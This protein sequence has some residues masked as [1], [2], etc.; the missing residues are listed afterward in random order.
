[1]SLAI[2]G[3]RERGNHAG[4]A[5]GDDKTATP[6]NPSPGPG[7]RG[8][9]R[10]AGAELECDPLAAPGCFLEE[11]TAGKEGDEGFLFLRAQDAGEDED[12][13]GAE[14][15]DDLHRVGA[16]DLAEDVGDDH[17]EPAPR[18]P[19]GEVASGQGD[20]AAV[21]AAQVGPGGGDGPGVA[22]EGLHAGGAEFFG[23]HGEDGGTGADVQGGPTGS[24]PPG[25]GAQEAK[26]GGGGGVLAGPESHGPGDAEQDTGRRLRGGPPA[27][28]VQDPQVPV[29]APRTAGGIG[30]GRE[31]QPVDPVELT[32]PLV[33]QLPQRGGLRVVGLEAGEGPSGAGVDDEIGF[34]QGEPCAPGFLVHG[35][36][37]APP[38][39]DVAAGAAGANHAATVDLFSSWLKPAGGNISGMI[40]S[41]AQWMAGPAG[42]GLKDAGLLVLRVWLGL[43]MLLLHGWGKVENY[44][45]LS[46]GFP[47]PLGVGTALSASLVIFA[48]VLC[49]LL[50]AVGLAARLASIPLVVTM[51][52]AFFVVHGGVLVGEGNGEMAFIYLAG[53]VAL[54]IAGPGRYSL[55]H[56]I[57]RAFRGGA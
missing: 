4:I 57:L 36:D 22:V 24:E 17:V 56:Y 18:S 33:L 54:L 1:M 31:G 20:P 5:F 34:R 27:A 41:Y 23:G 28:G 8:A 13:A 25:F 44:A 50:L 40:K 14:R 48:E 39:P 26:A 12:G 10:G 51:A 21:I 11:E 2:L 55:D 6:A 29:Q 37:A 53:F 15:G 47:D 49:A 52:V 43:S 19:G 30:A 7:R 42:D 16:Q 9:R 45:Q 3:G 38:T 35:G 32:A 46:Q